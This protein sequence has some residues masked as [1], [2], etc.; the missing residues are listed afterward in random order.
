MDWWR[1]KCILDRRDRASGRC[2]DRPPFDV[3]CNDE[4][5]ADRQYSAG[6]PR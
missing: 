1:M 4:A 6:D 2:A 3:G 5:G